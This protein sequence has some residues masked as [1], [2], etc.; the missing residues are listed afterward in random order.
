MNKDDALFAISTMIIQ[1][2][3]G[4]YMSAGDIKRAKMAIKYITD[5]FNTIKEDEA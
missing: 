2:R 1:T 5:V 3:N 4:Y